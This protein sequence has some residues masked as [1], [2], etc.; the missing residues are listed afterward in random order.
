M[1]GS[2]EILLII[3]LLMVILRTRYFHHLVEI[4]LV[5]WIAIPLI[6]IILW[7]YST[8]VEAYNLEQGFTTLSDGYHHSA[9]VYFQDTAL[10]QGEKIRGVFRATDHNLGTVAMR[11]DTYY[12]DNDDYLEFRIK[13]LNA[14][15]WY[16]TYRY[17]VDQF[18]PNGLFPFGFPIIIG[19]KGKDY[20]FEIESAKGTP[21]NSVGVS[22]IDPVFIAK[23]KYEKT[24]VLSSAENRISFLFNKILNLLK[25]SEFLVA[26]FIYLIPL[27]F[28]LLY[29]HSKDH[30]FKRSKTP[31]IIFKV[32]KRLLFSKPLKIAVKNWG[33]K[34]GHNAF[35]SSI[36]EYTEIRLR[37][38]ITLDVYG[39]ILLGIELSAILGS[40]LL[41]NQ[42]TQISFELTLFW[43]IL[44]Y[45]YSIPYRASLSLGL[46]FFLFTPLTYA[47]GFEFTAEKIVGWA[48]IFLSIS[49]FQL[50]A[51]VNKLNVSKKRII[52][53]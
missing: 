43:I 1:I 28:Y 7:S 38:L 51:E 41:T 36:L 5:K 3:G 21:D 12:R 19:S 49:I 53:K 39:L 25:K 52:V 40:I 37:W 16:Y 50:M 9:L 30:I 33:I 11:F 29:Q 14:V 27:I 13:E 8:I 24:E 45:L 34:G 17:K 42:P 6:L 4:K 18:Q 26:T 20:I 44:L 35:A 47:L 2:L 46:I 31:N 15:N 32:I 48:L 22:K 23:Y 10:L